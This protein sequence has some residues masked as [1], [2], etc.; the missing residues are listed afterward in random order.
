MHEKN[1]ILQGEICSRLT[2]GPIDSGSIHVGEI[3]GHGHV[4]QRRISQKRKYFLFE[5]APMPTLA[6]GC[7]LLCRTEFLI[8]VV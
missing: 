6:R 4:D 8:N 5:S 7:D 3:Y 1:F 2:F